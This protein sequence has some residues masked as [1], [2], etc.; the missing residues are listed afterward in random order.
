M[1]PTLGFVLAYMTWSVLIEQLMSFL[2]KTLIYIINIQNNGTYLE[3]TFIDGSSAAA[4]VG[5]ET[6]SE[7]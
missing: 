1:L 4:D 6:L 3:Q 5:G 2:I 7:Q